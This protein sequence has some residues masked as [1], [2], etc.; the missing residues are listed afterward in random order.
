MIRFQHLLD[1]H[2]DFKVLVSTL[3]TDELEL[4]TR[5]M[6]QTHTYHSLYVRFTPYYNIRNIDTSGS[7]PDEHFN[8]SPLTLFTPITEPT[9]SNEQIFI[10]FLKKHRMYS[11]YKRNLATLAFPPRSSADVVDFL[12]GAFSWTQSPEGITKWAHL[13]NAWSTLVVDLNLTTRS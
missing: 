5:H 3:N 13:G 6:S 1:S 9:L 12:S 2:T 11:A 8:E 4:L 10:M 7:H